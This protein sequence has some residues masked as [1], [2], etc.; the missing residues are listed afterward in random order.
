MMGRRHTPLAGIALLMAACGGGGGPPCVPTTD[1]SGIWNGTA[2]NDDVAR[3]NSGTIAA[4][5]TQSGCTLGGTWTFTF[6]DTFLDRT[7]EVTGNSPQTTAVTLDLKQCNGAAGSCDTVE[8]CDFLATGTLV[9]PSEINGSYTTGQNCSF[10]ES[11]SFDITLQAR[12]TPTPVPTTTPTA[13]PTAT[14]TTP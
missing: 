5:I 9:S 7:L 14:P 1:I 10:S 12:L 8:P 4:T 2:T 3:G 6:G 13:A 11:G